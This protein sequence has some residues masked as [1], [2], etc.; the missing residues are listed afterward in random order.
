MTALS[1][2]RKDL[3]ILLKDRGMVIQLFLLPLIFV[4]VFTGA[5][6]GLATSGEEKDT[7]IALPVVLLDRGAAGQTFLAG[8]DG[9]GGVRTEPYAEADALAKLK[10]NDIGFVLIIPADF[11]AKVASGPTATVAL[12]THPE[13]SAQQID[14]VRLVVEGVA[15][16]MTLETQILA[17]LQQIGDMVADAPPEYQQAFAAENTQAQARRQFE[18][19]RTAPLVS[20]AQTTPARPDKEE[21]PPFTSGQLAVPGF[22]VLFVFLAA[23][24]TARSVHDEKKIGSFRRLLA[25]PMSKATLLTG[26][27]LPNFIVALVQVV[28]IF[29]FGIVVMPLL[30]QPALSLGPTP[31]A[32]AV[33]LVLLALCSTALGVFI[34]ALARTDSQIG[35]L[36]TLI[37]WVAALIGGCLIPAFLLD[38][39]L[40]PVPKFV[41][42]YWANRALNDLMIRGAGFPGVTLE[43]AVLAGFTVLF[44][45]IGLWRF[46]YD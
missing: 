43:I 45:A 7:R 24:A 30:G 26:K 6:S 37:L 42:H 18:E 28:I 4:V 35:G 25:A 13:A 29:V 14:A 17:A 31:I 15:R 40:G 27:A 3:Q 36:S 32:L 2:A 33:V 10:E 41:P 46:D 22:T 38:R 11:S 20:V 16:D 44:F 12:V 34:A 5:L 23:Q 19:S 21:Q 8:I 39:F 9:A 1:I